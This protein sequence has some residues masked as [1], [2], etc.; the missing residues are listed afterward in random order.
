M[1]QKKTMAQRLEDY[2]NANLP[3]AI[4]TGIPLLVTFLFFLWLDVRDIKQTQK[5]QCER[6]SLNVKKFEFYNWM[7]QQQGLD[8]QQDQRMES[9]GKELD[10]LD[11]STQYIIR[12]HT[13]R[14]IVINGKGQD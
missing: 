12:L 9:F 10:K 13:S 2:V 11:E 8:K 3:K 1:N 7:Y 14:G 6:D 5:I 4:F